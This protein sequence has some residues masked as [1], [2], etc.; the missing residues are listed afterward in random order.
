MKKQEITII[1]IIIL[2][3]TVSLIQFLY[4]R[5]LWIDEA[6]LALNIINKDACDLLKPLDYGQIAPIL[7]LQAEKLFST[8]WPNTE[9]G[10]RLFPL[11]CFWASIFLFHRIVRKL[12]SD[13]YAKIVAISFFAL[14]YVFIYYSNEV[15]QYMADVFVLLSMFSTVLH[16]Y[17]SEVKKYCILAVT[18]AIAVFLS[19]VAPIILFTCGVYLFYNEFFVTKRKRIIPLLTV[20]VTWLGAFLFYYCFFIYGHPSENAMVDYWSGKWGF[21]PSNPFTVDFYKFLAVLSARLSAPL[22]FADYENRWMSG[23]AV[24]SMM[25]LFITGIVKLIGNKQIKTVIFTCT[26]LLLHVFLSAFQLYPC[27]GRL[28]LYTIPGIITVCVSGFGYILNRISLRLR[29][30]QFKTVAT[31]IVV[32]AVCLSLFSQ[33][34][35]KRIEMK[36]CI[37]YMQQNIGKSGNVYG[38]FSVLFVF[39]YYQEIGLV[40]NSVNWINDRKTKL[41]DDEHPILSPEDFIDL[42]V[43]RDTEMRF[44]HK[45]WLLMN[46]YDQE[47]YI[48][49]Q[50]DSLGYKRMDELK[51]KNASVYL[52][53]FGE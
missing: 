48:L 15:K 20:A 26:P 11:L 50:I 34:P 3:I 9:Y 46:R 6:M 1:L 23:F 40:D 35:Q 47:E 42:Y 52:Y 51:S 5:S 18:G 13:L 19:N 4:N 21:L 14:G 12:V 38:F 25:F 49:G 10:L 29:M 32:S 53:D 37:K 16:T 8:L 43:V 2:G 28:I 36:E 31:A 44:H 24:C 27:G 39:Q 41:T 30:K 45:V 17:K 7:F 33:F 22:F